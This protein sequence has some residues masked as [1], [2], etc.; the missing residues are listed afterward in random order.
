[1]SDTTIRINHDSLAIASKVAALFGVSQKAALDTAL[2][3]LWENHKNGEPLT[4]FSRE[5]IARV[6]DSSTSEPQTP[7]AP[8]TSEPYK[9][10]RKGGGK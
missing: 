10:T 7:V 5:H 3:E 4:I 8:A 9:M 2:I 6:A 1:M